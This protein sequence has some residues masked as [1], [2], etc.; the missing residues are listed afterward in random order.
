[1]G[2]IILTDTAINGVRGAKV[3]EPKKDKRYEKLVEEA[4][5]RIRQDKAERYNDLMKRQGW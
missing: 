5:E 4:N 1:M 3:V 2:K